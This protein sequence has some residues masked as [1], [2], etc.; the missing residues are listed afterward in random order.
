MK[1]F[2]LVA[3]MAV[4]GLGVSSAQTQKGDLAAGINLNY[5]IKSDWNNFGLGAK[6]QWSITDALRLEPSFNYFF[7]KDWISSWDLNV[8]LHYVFNLS[9]FEVYPLAGISLVGITA[10][11]PDLGWGL[12][13]YSASETKF[14]FNVGAGAQYWVTSKIGVNLDLKYQYVAH[15]DGFV[16]GLGGTY[17]F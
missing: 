9:K 1:K 7:K 8:N 12:G 4:V 11:T 10:S 5:G 13:S 3:I 16:I 17:K 15:W 2:L 6:F 14:G